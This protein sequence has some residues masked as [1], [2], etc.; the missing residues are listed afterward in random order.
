MAGPRSRSGRKPTSD[1]NLFATD[2][3]VTNRAE[4]LYEWTPDTNAPS[5]SQIPPKSGSGSV[6]R[7]PLSR[8]SG[9]FKFSGGIGKP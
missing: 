2:A 9:D 3:E 8:K 4:A 6:N 1:V 7:A 5:F